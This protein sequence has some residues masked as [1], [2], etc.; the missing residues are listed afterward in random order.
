MFIDFFSLVLNKKLSFRTET[1][2]HGGAVLA[3][4]RVVHFMHKIY[5]QG[6]VPH[7]P[8]VHVR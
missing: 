8:F 2:L 3:R 4:Q 5:V 1:A 6:D 7:Q